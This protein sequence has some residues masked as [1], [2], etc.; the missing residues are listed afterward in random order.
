MAHLRTALALLISTSLVAACGGGGGIGGIISPTPSPTNTPGSTGS[1][2]IGY[3]CPSSVNGS[4]VA[5]STAS[6]TNYASF[7]SDAARRAPQSSA[8]LPA[9]NPNLLEVE[10]TGSLPS[11]GRSPLDAQ[12][13]QLGGTVMQRFAFTHIGTSVDVIAVNPNKSTTIAAQLRTQPG[14]LRVAPVGLR[15]TQG[16]S[17]PITTNDPYFAG[18][19][20]SS[21][22]YFEA[23]NP[24]A[25]P[26]PGTSL[27]GQWDMHAI[28][29]GYA[30]AYSSS[31]DAPPGL[32]NASAI[33]SATIPIAIIDTGADVT[34]PELGGAK[35]VHTACF[36]T[37][38]AGTA[39]STSQYVTDLDGH[40]TNV[41]GIAAADINNSLGFVGV[42]GNVSLIIERVFPSPP[43][44]CAAQLSSNPKAC[45]VSASTADI[46]SAINDAIAAG[47]KVINM[48]LGASCV[49]GD[50]PLEGA[51]VANAIAQNVTVVAASGNENA[52][53]LDAPACDPGVI[54]V[55]AS[56]LADSYPTA[57]YPAGNVGTPGTPIEYVANYSNY[58]AGSTTWGLVAP[59]GDPANN[60][61]G[62]D[63]LHWIENIYSSTALGGGS[64]TP[65]FDAAV[66]SQT[67]CR[68]LIAGT[69]QATPHV[70][71]AAA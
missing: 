31:S 27:P 23:G 41:A 22:P 10:R 30:W 26:A 19:P 25:S 51:A 6:I 49:G 28:S 42:G 67:D 69:S 2:S 59:G 38:A 56:A 18:F 45:D 68:I 43:S 58:Q 11:N 64:C 37:N 46:A 17:A 62:A 34:H 21:A 32:Q 71:G 5:R 33:G 44:N 29:L 50:D 54:A 61:P 3:T 47:A 65:D 14:V 70:A 12:I 20:G 48:S 55:G 57:T 40:G 53:T 9:T 52:N 1:G 63:D 24:A 66:G 60:G 7:G 35:I 8:T 4:S 39:Q 13:A 15:Y 16:V 36:I